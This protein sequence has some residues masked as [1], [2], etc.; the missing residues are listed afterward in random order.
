MI[1]GG[2]QLI[3]GDTNFDSQSI[4]DT[5]LIRPNN[6][7]RTKYAEDSAG[8]AKIVL[9]HLMPAAVC[10]IDNAVTELFQI[11]GCFKRS[12]PNSSPRYLLRLFCI[13]L[14]STAVLMQE[15]SLSRSTASSL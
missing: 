6:L 5:T 13:G 3:D 14:T 9:D 10:R 4:A 8:V 15:F 7:I 11:G 12:D 1:I 2:N